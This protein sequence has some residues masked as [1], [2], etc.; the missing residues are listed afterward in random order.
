MNTEEFTFI[1]KMSRK[2]YTFHLG[3]IGDKWAARVLHGKEIIATSTFTGFKEKIQANDIA[4]FFQHNLDSD[5]HLEVELHDWVNRFKR[6]VNFPST[7]E[8]NF[9]IM[10]NLAI[11]VGILLLVFVYSNIRSIIDMSN[12]HVEHEIYYNPLLALSMFYTAFALFVWFIIAVF[13]IHLIKMWNDSKKTFNI[14]SELILPLIGHRENVSLFSILPD[15]FS[16]KND[17][18]KTCIVVFL[19]ALDQSGNQGEIVADM[20]SMLARTFTEILSSDEPGISREK[21]HSESRSLAKESI[22]VLVQSGILHTEV[23]SPQKNSKII[24]VYLT[25]QGETLLS[26][27]HQE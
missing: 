3:W 19:K 14:V 24:K 13:L 15:F 9:K 26:E 2:K 8:K 6:Y 4:S 12:N 7:I 10:R 20:K 18:I 11:I 25:K 5:T 21:L 23:G 22:D 1:A 17:S 27:Y 16:T